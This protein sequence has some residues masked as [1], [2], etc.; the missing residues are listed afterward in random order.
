[1]MYKKNEPIAKRVEDLLSKM[2]LKEKL[3]QLS[4][5]LPQKL[6][7]GNK[8]D[9]DKLDGNYSDGLG[10]I[11]QYSMVGLQ[12]PQFIAKISNEIQHYFVEKTRLGIPVILQ[13]ESLSGYPAAGGTMFPS[14]LNAASTFNPELM[15]KVSSIISKES[16]AVGIRQA[17][18]P[19][20]DVAREPRWGRVYESFG[21]D[22]YLV[23]QMGIAYTK[24]LQKNKVDGVLATGK[25]FLGYAE[26]QAG[27]NT[28][29][30]RLCDRELYETFATPFEAGIK[31]ADL[32]S[33][34]TSY[35]EIDGIPCGA[36]KKIVRELLRKKMGFKGVVVSDGGAVWKLFNT[37]GIAKDYPEAG[38]LG[39]KGG[40]E[41]E[42]PVGGAYRQLEKYVESGELDIS[43]IDEAVSNVLTSK[44]ELGLFENPYV[45]EAVVINSMSNEESVE[46][47]KK[48]TEE[49]II[50]L[51][52]EE[53]ILPLGTKKKVAVIGPHGGLMRPS[54]SGYTA[55]AYY[56]L[57][58]EMKSDSKEEPTFHGIMDEKQ[59]A[60]NEKKK[61]ENAFDFSSMAELLG[62]KFDPEITLKNNYKSTSLVEELKGK[63]NISYEKGCD[64]VG[65]N[66]KDFDNAVE[67]AKNSDVVIMTLGGN[68][69]WTNCTGG[70]GKD[71]TSLNL[72][73]VQQQLLDAVENTG[74]DIIVILYGPG[75]Y[76]PKFTKNVKAVINA[77][78]PGPYGGNA[79]AKI[80]YGEA[81]PSGKLPMTM[82]RNVGQVPIYYYHKTGSGYTVVQKKDGLNAGEIFAGGYVDSENTPLYPFGHG[83]SYTSFEIIDS[84][85]KEKE[86]STDGIIQVACTVKNVG[87]RT[88]AEVVQL[89]YRDCEAHVTR[90]V[91]QLVGF[92]KVE[93]EAG[94]SVQLTFKLNTS[95]LGFYNEDMEFVVEPGNAELMLGNSS[96]NFVYKEK[97]KLIGKKVNVMGK[98]IYTCQ[99]ITN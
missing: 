10:R 55:M 21:E 95:Q 62:N 40:M 11:T 33:I 85:V 35:S 61:T 29:A 41:T 4:S 30:T 48:L 24:G 38:L 65:N 89:Y 91:R 46:V 6:L 63:V 14:M 31:E 50:L 69:G 43:I 59:K 57:I 8:L 96:E 51:K 84:K 34:M 81:N 5:E 52:N 45:D 26:T 36:N 82:P 3:A 16:K 76:A 68:C 92:K 80:L 86:I 66:T 22:P 39:I 18:S 99:V 60:K 19:L 67:V 64:I 23:A 9:Y 27:L 47:S 12:S 58:M 32:G 13:A 2:T 75:P 15:Q 74:K 88:G 54:I 71:R 7:K 1:M 77:W 87:N 20:F 98:R 37:F 73:G 56:E 97:V 44:F 90:P 42:M 78:L 17:L 53:S 83:L 94:E 72:P 25:H 70:E 49:S 79:I 28:A 93:L